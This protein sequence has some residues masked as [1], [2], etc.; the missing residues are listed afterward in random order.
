MVAPFRIP[1]DGT[2]DNDLDSTTIEEV[3]GMVDNTSSSPDGDAKPCCAKGVELPSDSELQFYLTDEKGMVKDENIVMNEPVPKI[4]LH[5]R[6]NVLVCWPEKLTK[7]YDTSLLSS[8]PEIFKSGFFAKRP[9]ES[10][11]LYN[12][13]EA[14]LKEE[15]LGPEDM[16]SV[17][18]VSH[19]YNLESICI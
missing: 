4:G 16:W 2:L 12:C 1:P 14:F 15:P 13:L 19:N 18:F 17:H 10:V 11:S 6:F 7:Q 8:L 9:Q 5:R 3:E